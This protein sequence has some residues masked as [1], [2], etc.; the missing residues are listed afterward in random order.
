M[1]KGPEA[2]GFGVASKGISRRLIVP[3]DFTD[4]VINRVETRATVMVISGKQDQDNE[5][6]DEERE[7]KNKTGDH[8]NTYF[9]FD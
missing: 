8:E 4:A 7:G 2:G 6:E 3:A 9:L 1:K 5:C